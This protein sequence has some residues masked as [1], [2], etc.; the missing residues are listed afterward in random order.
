MDNMLRVLN[1]R[2]TG[3]GD[4]TIYHDIMNMFCKE[5]PVTV[6]LRGTLEN[7]FAAEAMDRLFRD[8]A[9]QQHEDELLF[10]TLVDLMGLAVAKVRPSVH[11]AYQHR[12]EQMTVTIKA[13][14]DKLKGVETQ[15]SRALVRDT[16]EQLEKLIVSM[17]GRLPRLLPGYRTKI[18]DGNHLRRTDRRLKPLR[19]LNA[20]PL[21]GQA[22][23]VLDPA[24]MLMTDV[25]PCEDGHAQERSLLPN[26]LRTVEAGDLW[27]EDRNFCT[28]A[29]VCG[30]DEKNAA[31]L[32][33][34]HAALPYVAAGEKKRRGRCSTGVVYEEPVI[35]TDAQK[36]EHRFRHLV[37]YLDEPTR[38]GE[39]EIHLLTNLPKRFTARKLADLYRQRWTI[40]AAFGEI[41]AAFHG[42]INTL[43]Y[44]PAALLGFCL[45]L[46]MYNLLSVIK[47]AIRVAHGVSNETISTY[48]LAEEIS[49]TYRGMMIALPPPYWKEEFGHLTVPQ[50][51]LK[52]I[53]L[54][55]K[56]H[57]DHFRKH[58]RGPK[59][60]PIKKFNKKHRGHVS[61]KRI[62]EQNKT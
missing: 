42:E 8:Y 56:V 26:V 48:H 33:R 54:A 24:L 47:A 6:M 17:K 51:A 15:V 21:P 58:P 46:T 52:L 19:E 61:T 28:V 53:A 4:M 27:I 1:L 62:L 23:V 5:S 20:A 43:A 60:L 2:L 49:C 16:A 41:A 57:L 9:C 55:K 22:L 50:L 59:T 7:V 38:D 12:K 31:F 18:L 36:Q 40:E 3:G 29:F 30:I 34:L 32:V 14:Y 25:F 39:T 13:V 45:A 11:A 10:S 37:I 44:P 35:V